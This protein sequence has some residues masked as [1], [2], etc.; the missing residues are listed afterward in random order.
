M[1]NNP[2]PSDKELAELYA[3]VIKN[4]SVQDVAN[5]HSRIMTESSEIQRSVDIEYVLWLKEEIAKINSFS[6][7]STVFYYKG[8]PIK[9]DAETIRDFAFIGLSTSDFITD[10]ITSGYFFK[11]VISWDLKK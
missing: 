10:F 1:T 9:I 8:V 4:K 5:W 6:L 7:D 2:F 3:D 11:N